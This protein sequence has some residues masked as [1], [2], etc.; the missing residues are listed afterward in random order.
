M[1]KTVKNGTLKKDED[2][3]K[4]IFAYFSLVSGNKSQMTIQL[5]AQLI[6]LKL[7]LKLLS[8]KMT[9]FAK[10]IKNVLSFFHLNMF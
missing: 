2:H 6:G 5:W 9:I 7:I 8:Q 1:H 4:V 10:N 3:D